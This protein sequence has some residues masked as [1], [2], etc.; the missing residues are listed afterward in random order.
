MSCHSCFKLEVN[1]EDW[2]VNG[3]ENEWEKGVETPHSSPHCIDMLK[4]LENDK[5]RNKKNQDRR[6]LPKRDFKDYISRWP[7]TSSFYN[8][9]KLVTQYTD[10]PGVFLSIPQ[11][12]LLG[13]SVHKV[14]ERNLN[15]RYQEVKIQNELRHYCQSINF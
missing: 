11:W 14:F 4:V 2:N 12:L 5:E 3:L 9:I 6:F 8:N 10:C 1:L 15:F 13:V 7:K